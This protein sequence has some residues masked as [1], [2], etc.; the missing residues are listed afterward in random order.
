MKNR[1]GRGFSG[2]QQLGGNVVEL[3][4][5]R[6]PTTQQLFLRCAR[7]WRSDADWQLVY[8]QRASLTAYLDNVVE[9]PRG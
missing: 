8:Q 7:A 4:L 5:P 2:S 9:F 3:I 6:S 1:A